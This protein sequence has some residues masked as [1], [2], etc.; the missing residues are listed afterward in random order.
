MCENYNFNNILNS[1]D[2]CLNDTDITQIK[3]SNNCKKCNSPCDYT[4]DGLICPHC[5]LW[6]NHLISQK[7]EW[8]MGDDC[9]Q[10]ESRCGIP[11]NPLLPSISLGCS[12]EKRYN[13]NKWTKEFQYIT[14]FTRWNSV[15]HIEK[16]LYEDLQIYN[17]IA[18]A[19]CIN[20]KIIHSAMYYY[21][22]VCKYG[23]QFRKCNKQGL[24][25]S[26]LFFACKENDYPHSL[27]EITQMFNIDIKHISAG[28]KNL[29][30]I[31]CKKNNDFIDGIVNQEEIIERYAS[32]IGFCKEYILLSSFIIIQINKLKLFSDKIPETITAGVLYF[33]ACNFIHSPNRYNNELII[34]KD[35]LNLSIYKIREKI[36]KLVFISESTIQK[37]TNLIEENKDILFPQSML[38]KY[39]KS[40]KVS[41]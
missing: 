23:H 10:E 34:N 2:I 19:Y 4:D 30:D 14:N 39:C 24:M 9:C 13:T 18:E 38:K 21:A 12:V 25:A 3:Q 6:S 5:K 11:S 16:I 40:Q 7:P 8:K 29:S 33:I 35:I 20:K 31:I 17:G 22:E 26:A 28:C 1:F 37:C 36:H 27:R 32:L 15:P 41:F